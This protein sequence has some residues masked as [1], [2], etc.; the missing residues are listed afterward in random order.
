ML[1]IKALASS[2][3]YGDPNQPYDKLPGTL[4]TYHVN[5]ATPLP[6]GPL[7]VLFIVP[8]KNAREVVEL[9]QRL[10]LRYTV[11]MNA[12]KS[13]WSEGYTE[14]VDPSPL[15]RNQA[16]QVVDTLAHER[17]ALEKHYDAIVIGAVSWEVIP[18]DI[19]AL[20]TQHIRRGTALIYVSPHRSLSSWNQET[21]EA[22]T[23]DPQYEA[24]F[25][26]NQEPYLTSR[27]IA[28]LPIDVI[29]LLPVPSGRKYLD[30][31]LSWRLGSAPRATQDKTSYSPL[32]QMLCTVRATHEGK[33]RIVALDFLDKGGPQN[34]EHSLTPNVYYDP[35]MYDYTM[36]LLARCVLYGVHGKAGTSA[37]IGVE[38]LPQPGV[39]LEDC[40]L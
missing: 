40:P 13:S 32:S 19:R 12:G 30:A 14:G 9:R 11:I 7:N 26:T 2:P 36:A 4:E 25:K 3:A 17:L 5:W 1:G 29:P 33:G 27:I 28:D 31:E 39:P 15:P 24:L 18:A 16:E 20:I 23:P 22:T 10:D 35:V 37:R 6:G 34:S 8:Y 38:K 21:A